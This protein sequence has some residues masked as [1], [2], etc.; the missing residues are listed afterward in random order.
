MTHISPTFSVSPQ[1]TAADIAAI[2]AAGYRAIICNRPDN[3]G[4]DQP[5]F[6]EIAAAARAADLK[7]AYIPVI[8]GAVTQDNVTA[9]AAA[10]KDLP[11]P[12]LA[13]CRSGA[14]AASLWSL[15]DGKQP[16]AV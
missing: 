11:Q 6:A 7:T 14:R 16:T 3:E 9:L 4:A 10:L 2:K 8:P 15:C 12:V 5:A 13:Y 1:I